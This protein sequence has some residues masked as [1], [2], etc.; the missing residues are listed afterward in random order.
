[1]SYTIEYDRIFLKSKLGYTALWLHGDNNVYERTFSGRDRRSRDWGIMSDFLGVSEDYMIKQFESYFNDYDEH[2]MR[3]GK[4]LTNKQTITWIKMGC[5]SAVTVEELLELNRP[6]LD[7]VAYIW[8]YDRKYENEL[9]RYIR[10]TADLDNWITDFKT[11]TKT[12]QGYRS[13]YFPKIVLDQEKIKKPQK[14]RDIDDNDKYILKGRLGYVHELHGRNTIS[15][16]KN[17]QEAQEYTG[18]DIQSIFESHAYDYANLKPMKKN[19]FPYNAVIE[20][21]YHGI[22]YISEITRNRMRFASEKKYAKHYKNIQDA[23]KHIKQLSL[24]YKIPMRAVLD[25]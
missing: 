7:I 16:T 5:N 19:D 9:R 6:Y 10:T 12:H 23:E 22:C 20:A 18:L 21:D 24:R 25:E 11:F 4:Y 14:D 1:M 13:E 15:Y 2:W 3:F 8:D 17:I